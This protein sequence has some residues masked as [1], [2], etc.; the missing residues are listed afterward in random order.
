MTAHH[1]ILRVNESTIIEE[2]IAIVD[3]EEIDDVLVFD[4]KNDSTVSNVA[5]CLKL[6][7]ECSSTTTVQPTNN[8]PGWIS[9]TDYAL[10][11]LP[12]Y[13]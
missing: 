10:G 1:D 4:L 13:A 12:C 11:L 9:L 5:A 2:D 6:S 3:G 8:P 7:L